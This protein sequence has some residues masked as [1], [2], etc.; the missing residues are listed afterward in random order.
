M[1]LL[2]KESEKISHV[3]ITENFY[4]SKIKEVIYLSKRHPHAPAI[5]ISENVVETFS[6]TWSGMA[7]G[8][9]EAGWP[10]NL[11]TEPLPSPVGI[12]WLPAVHF[13][14]LPKYYPSLQP[15]QL[16]LVLQ[17]RFLLPTLPFLCSELKKDSVSV[18]QCCPV[19][20]WGLFLF[21]LKVDRAWVQK[22]I[23]GI[24]YVPE[25]PSAPR[26]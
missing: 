23:D 25:C 9:W 22:G 21:P 14:H 11:M 19:F 17:D 4:K 7:W 2:W 15:F 1:G 13:T 20:L 12:V 16:F 5:N 10:T 8:R 6:F 3:H 24:L 26:M 18:N